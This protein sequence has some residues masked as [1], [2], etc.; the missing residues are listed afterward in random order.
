MA[1]TRAMAMAR[2]RRLRMGQV[3]PP[4]PVAAL[5]KH[6]YLL[7]GQPP[8][9][10]PLHL[11]PRL[12]PRPCLH[13]RLHPRLRLRLPR[14][15]QALPAAV[16]AV[17]SRLLSPPFSR[18]LRLRKRRVSGSG[19]Q[20]Q[21]KRLAALRPLQL[22]WTRTKLSSGMMMMTMM[23]IVMIIMTMMMMT[24]PLSPSEQSVGQ[25]LMPLHAP[26]A[27]R[28]SA[29]RMLQLLY[30]LHHQLLQHRR[31]APRRWPWIPVLRTL[32]ALLLQLQAALC[33]ALPLPQWQRLRQRLA[34]AA[35]AGILSLSPTLTSLWAEQL[36][37]QV[38]EQQAQQQPMQRRGPSTRSSLLSSSRCTLRLLPL[39]QRTPVQALALAELP[40]A[41]RS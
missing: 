26:A 3:L 36:A 38:A 16:L 33:G 24:Q 39:L 10:L 7:P 30:Q 19:P 28:S 2:R 14:N 40:Q 29:R 25:L 41:C 34:M 5:L 21:W 15:Q 4:S 11:H 37:E 8:R 22:Q 32:R 18:P 1:R 20:R 31:L 6:R 27:A 12:R 23:S 17:A 9:Q 35:R 13:P